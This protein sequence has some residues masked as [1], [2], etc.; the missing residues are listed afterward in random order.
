[1]TEPTRNRV[2]GLRGVR[3]GE[4]LLARFD[5]TN[6]NAEVWNTLG[7]NDCPPDEF[8]ALDAAAIA[9]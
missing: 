9:A 8:A 3:Y 1:M 6:F 7:F 2:D 5:G 4:I